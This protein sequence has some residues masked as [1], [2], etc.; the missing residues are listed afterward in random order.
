MRG[1]MTDFIEEFRSTPP[2]GRRLV[3]NSVLPAGVVF[4]STPPCGR[5]PSGKVGCSIRLMFRS[6]PPCGRRRPSRAGGSRPEVSIH[7]SVWE[8]TPAGWRKPPGSF[9]P[10]LRVGGDS[11]GLADAPPINGFRSTPPCGRRQVGCQTTNRCGGFRSTPPCGRRL[12]TQPALVS[13]V[14]FRSTPPRGRRRD[15]TVMRAPPHC[16]DP[17]L[18]VGG[19]NRFGRSPVLGRVSIHASVWEATCHPLLVAQGRHVS[20]HAS[21]WEATIA[22]VAR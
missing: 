22:A 8:A 21:V 3:M 14:M 6:T 20:I 2:C 15:R 9:D 4:R 16:F 10:R 13:P 11:R 19:D 18:R 12:L 5:R 17:R 7:A 1:R